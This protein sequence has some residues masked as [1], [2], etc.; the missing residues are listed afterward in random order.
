MEEMEM[1]R[2]SEMLGIGGDGDLKIK[3]PQ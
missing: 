2:M 3:F 1:I